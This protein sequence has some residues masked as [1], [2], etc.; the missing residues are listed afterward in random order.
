MRAK[1]RA[2]TIVLVGSITVLVATSTQADAVLEG[3]DSPYRMQGQFIV[4]LKND[5]S[6]G[7]VAHKAMKTKS[8]RDAAHISNKARI[9]SLG[10]QMLGTRGALGKTFTVTMKGFS[11]YVTESDARVLAK[12]S[13][14]ERIVAVMRTWSTA[15][16][17]N[18]PEHLDRIDQENLPL[19]TLYNY[20]STGSFATPNPQ[21]LYQLDV[22]VVDSGVRVTHNEF[23]GRFN[24][25]LDFE[26]TANATPL[27]TAVPCNGHGTLVAGVLGGAT[28]GVAKG[29]T[30]K[31]LRI[32]T[33]QGGGSSADMVDA[34]QYITDWAEFYGITGPGQPVNGVR[35]YTPVL[36]NMSVVSPENSAVR[37]A[38]NN[39]LAAGVIWVA[40]AGNDEVDACNLLPG[41]ISGVINVT[42]SEVSTSLFSG[43]RDRV[44]KDVPNSK[45]SNYGSC[46][47]I[48]APGQNVRSA[49][50]GSN[51]DTDN[52][53]SGTSLAA[54]QVA[55]V[56][57]LYLASNPT[58]TPAQVQTAIINAATVGKIEGDLKG[59]P[60][61]LLSTAVPGNPIPGSGDDPSG[62]TPA[63]TAAINAVVN[64]LLLN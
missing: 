15:I 17:Q 21:R 47:D 64:M 49:F 45:G 22:F 63:V 10:R 53:F 39:S 8:E 50:I 27:G 52:T 19:N 18:A 33:C 12:D 30:M 37:S 42:A 5:K 2:L 6:M 35:Y 23:G 28:Y 62:L 14:V 54:P 29:V 34:I 46:V 32:T 41:A 9:E 56:A 40:G 16:Q 31:S 61:R 4:V 26:G 1:L 58:A 36:A 55:G 25:N 60:N 3:F 57:A 43:E 48:F 7:W 59:S 20:F 24:L 51:T 44:W 11:A 13:R 38:I